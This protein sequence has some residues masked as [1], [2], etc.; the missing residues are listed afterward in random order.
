[1]TPSEREHDV[2]LIFDFANGFTNGWERNRRCLGSNSANT[3]RLNHVY[4]GYD[5]FVLVFKSWTHNPF[6]LGVP[7]D[8]SSDSLG[9]GADIAGCFS[10]RVQSHTQFVLHARHH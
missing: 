5:S 4:K 3:Q 2:M 10:S 8:P 6:A 1:M 7:V 9:T